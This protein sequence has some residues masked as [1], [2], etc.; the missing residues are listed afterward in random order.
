[1]DAH[2]ENRFIYQRQPASRREFIEFWA[3]RYFDPNERLYTTNINR[4]RTAETLSELFK[5][6]IGHR[7]FATMLKRTVEPHFLSRIA[8]VRKLPP[9]VSA[10][11]F[12]RKFPNGGVI[13]RIF[14]L[15]CWYPNRY[16]I[17]DQ[18]AHR[19]AVFIRDGRMDELDDYGD[20]KKIDQYL[21]FYVS[22]FEQL[23]GVDVPFELELDGVPGRKV[24]RA[25]WTFGKSLPNSSLPPLPEVK[26][27]RLKS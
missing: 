15:H 19:A 27:D 14:W 10:E 24:D 3:A 17:Y 21:H 12:L 20:A 23:R 13:H 9:D 7:L 4:P 16:P 5:W 26:R 6:K 18:H 11:D 22:F 1:M 25:L 8:D 2:S